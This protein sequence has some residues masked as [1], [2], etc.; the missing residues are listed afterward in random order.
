MGA[1][2]FSKYYLSGQVSE[3]HIVFNVKL[4]DWPTYV[5]VHVCIAGVELVEV[6]KRLS[7][8]IVNMSILER[9]WVISIHQCWI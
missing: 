9:A 2:R 8:V 4:R 6:C 5:M 3:S 1:V 7:R